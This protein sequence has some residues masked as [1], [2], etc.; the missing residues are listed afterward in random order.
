MSPEELISE[1]NECFKGFDEI[2]AKYNLEKIKTM[3][4]GYLCAGGLPITN[5]TNPVDAIK[6]A[7]E[8]QV[9]M[10]QRISEKEKNKIPYWNMRVG[11]HTGG[12]IAGVVGTQKFAYDIWGDTV[13]TA[14]R[15]E[16]GCEIGKINISETT[17][18][19]V[20]DQ[21][22]CSYRGEIEIKHGNKLGMYFV[23]E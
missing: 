3:G 11:I 18:Q 15:M 16:S 13:N 2:I 10:Q 1:L 19:L 20:K 22:D 17:Y 23:E 21:F 6:A 14:S 7:K 5:E 12:V 9:F 8:M 4:D